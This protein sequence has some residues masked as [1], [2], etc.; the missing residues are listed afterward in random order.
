MTPA[1]P[2]PP[3]PQALPYATP[4]ADRRVLF[5]HEGDRATVV[6]PRPERRRKAAAKATEELL[7]EA[8]LYLIIAIVVLAWLAPYLLLAVVPGGA[9]VVAAVYWLTWIGYARLDRPLV[10]ELTPGE[11]IF[12]NTDERR[13]PVHLSREGLYAIYMVSYAP[14]IWIRRRGQEMFGLFATPDRGESERIASF[15]RD[16]AGLDAEASGA[17]AATASA[18]P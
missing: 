8:L 18:R 12:L 1:P 5:T 4:G 11:L 9:V 17:E 15:L 13:R 3:A 10:I 14:T 7:G 2:A 6:I 16:F